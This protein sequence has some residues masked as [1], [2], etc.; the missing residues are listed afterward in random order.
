MLHN[1]SA[2]SKFADPGHH[3]ISVE[4]ALAQNANNFTPADARCNQT[5]LW[6]SGRRQA[7]ELCK[8]HEISCGL[9]VQLSLHIR[10]CTSP[11]VPFTQVIYIDVPTSVLY[12]RC[13][14][15]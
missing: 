12:K 13:L 15:A 11:S 3:Q 7:F 14:L 10:M 6:P 2:A 9:C 4:D 8:S 1:E 5:M